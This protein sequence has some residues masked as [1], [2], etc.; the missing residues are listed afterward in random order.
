MVREGRTCLVV[1]VTESNMEAGTYLVVM[2]TEFGT[3]LVFPPVSGCPPGSGWGAPFL[4]GASCGEW[5][6]D[7]HRWS[8]C[9]HLNDPEG[10]HK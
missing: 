8:L 3:Y 4:R 7:G 10:R 5:G 2:V 1:M 9:P 6:Q